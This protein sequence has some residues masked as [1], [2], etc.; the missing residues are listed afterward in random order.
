MNEQSLRSFCAKLGIRLTDY[1]STKGW[2]QAPCPLAPWLHA[3]KRDA[4]PS[5]AV[6][7]SNTGVSSYKCMSCHNHGTINKLAFQLARYRDDPSLKE[8]A[9]DIQR[10]EIRGFTPP[11]WDAADHVGRSDTETIA[12]ADLYPSYIEYLPARDYIAS[13]GITNHCALSLGLRADIERG[14][15]LFPVYDVR[16]RFRGFTGR[17]I[18][19]PSIPHTTQDNWRRAERGHRPKVR[20][21]LGL[22]KRALLLGEHQVRVRPGARIVLVEGLFAYARLRQHGIQN[23]VALLGSVPTPEKAETLLRWDL[24]VVCLLDNDQA[25]QHGIYG[26]FNEEGRRIE[27]L[28]DCLYGRVPLLMASWPEG[29]TDPDELTKAEAIAVVRDAELYTA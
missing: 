19:L 6:C 9:N 3:S 23:V 16:R 27:G 25:G 29:K 14:R 21:Y 22:P 15:V 18:E 5:F 1:V 11:D 7:V 12:N 17:A 26:F 13:R 10:Q 28:V 2:I 8:I 24:P 4:H 20:D